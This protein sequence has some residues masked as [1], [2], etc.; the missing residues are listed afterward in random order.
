MVVVV[1]SWAM[2]LL[3]VVLTGSGGTLLDI[4]HRSLEGPE[5]RRMT[6]GEPREEQQRASRAA[7]KHL[8]DHPV[9]EMTAPPCPKGRS[10]GPW[11]RLCFRGA[12]VKHGSLGFWDDAYFVSQLPPCDTFRQRLDAA[13]QDKARGV[14][15]WGRVG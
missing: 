1:V 3:F 7:F 15:L 12:P 11:A 10:E 9:G 8:K 5:R 14:C 6:Q 2:F 13:F 4:R